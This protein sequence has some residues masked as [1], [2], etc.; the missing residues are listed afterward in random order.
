MPGGKLTGGVV[1]ILLFGGGGG[2]GLHE[3]HGVGEALM[4][5]RGSVIDPSTAGS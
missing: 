3:I 4:A 2:G 1:G 5:G